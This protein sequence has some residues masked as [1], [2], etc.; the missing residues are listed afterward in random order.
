[1]HDIAPKCAG[2]PEKL[3]RLITAIRCTEVANVCQFDEA[4]RNL[5]VPDNTLCTVQSRRRTIGPENTIVHFVTCPDGYVAMVG[6]GTNCPER[7]YV[8]KVARISPR[9]KEEKLDVAGRWRKMTG[10]PLKEEGSTTE[11][12]AEEDED[13]PSLD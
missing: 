10:T 2:F 8:V 13:S 12:V 1:M 6:K 7:Q 5:D 11:V 3:L 9:E 4:P